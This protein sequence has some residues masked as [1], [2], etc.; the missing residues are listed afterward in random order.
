MHKIEN[1]LQ[2]KQ[3]EFENQKIKQELEL[4]ARAKSKT[5]YDVTKSIR[6]VPKFQEK[7]VD[8]CFIHFE[9]IA[10]NLK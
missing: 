1:E 7:D 5:E 4:E 2:I 3:L 8:K 6:L 9:K 10:E